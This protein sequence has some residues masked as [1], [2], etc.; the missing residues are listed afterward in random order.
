M[1]LY[2]RLDKGDLYRATALALV[3]PETSKVK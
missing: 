2:G 1:T 3:G